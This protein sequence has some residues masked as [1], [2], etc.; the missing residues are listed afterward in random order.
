MVP[1]VS[2]AR[3]AFLTSGRSTS[4][5]SVP[6]FWREGSATPSWSTRSRMMST[7]RWMASEVTFGC[8]GVGW[9]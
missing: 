6:A 3:L 8:W 2:I 1:T 4:I 9:A 7:E 5:W